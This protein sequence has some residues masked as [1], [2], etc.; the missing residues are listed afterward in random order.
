MYLMKVLIQRNNKNTAPAAMV[1]WGCMSHF[2]NLPMTV[3][4]VPFISDGDSSGNVQEKNES[5]DLLKKPG[6]LPVSYVTKKNRYVTIT[7]RT[8][9][10][11]YALPRSSSLRGY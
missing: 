7:G 6:Y 1:Q 11:A 4:T 3:A 2:L 8:A 10:T 9:C 5:P